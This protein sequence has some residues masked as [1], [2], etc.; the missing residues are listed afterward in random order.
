MDGVTMK[1][2]PRT[3][4]SASLRLSHNTFVP[5]HLRGGLLEITQLNTLNTQ[6]QQGFA[7]MLLQKVCAEADKAGIVLLLHPKPYD[8]APLTRE[9]LADWY[10]RFG[11]DVIQTHPATLMARPPG[12]QPRFKAKPLVFTLAGA[13]DS[14][15]TAGA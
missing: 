14:M 2:G 10:S 9:Q 4:G 12:A 8:D 5:A 6:R 7:S 15:E 13:I 1:P 3:H 11:F